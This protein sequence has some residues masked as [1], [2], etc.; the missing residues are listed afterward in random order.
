MAVPEI[1][2]WKSEHARPLER[3]RAAVTQPF[4]RDYNIWPGFASLSFFF[5]FFLSGIISHKFRFFD[6]RRI[7]VYTHTYIYMNSLFIRLS[8]LGLSTEVSVNQ[9]E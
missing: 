2:E 9:L 1:C 3:K 4:T 6:Q 5:P 8:F 7:V